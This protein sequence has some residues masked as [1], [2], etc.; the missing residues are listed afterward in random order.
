MSTKTHRG[1]AEK[2]PGFF[3]GERLVAVWFGC[4][5]A[6]M[7]H[8]EVTSSLA[9]DPP[10]T[11]ILLVHAVVIFFVIHLFLNPEKW[12]DGIVE[13]DGRRST[14]TGSAAG[15]GGGGGP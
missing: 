5:N 8:H 3:I 1:T 11:P 9:P 14:M 15:F 2:P 13:N 6:F 12:S 7:A 10:M 4:L